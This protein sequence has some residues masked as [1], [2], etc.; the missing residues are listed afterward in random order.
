[1]TLQCCSAT[2]L[3]QTNLYIGKTLVQG[4]INT[5]GTDV[6]S[7]YTAATRIEGFIN[8]FGDS[9]SA[10]TSIL[11]SQNNGGKQK[12]RV[13]ESFHCSLIYLGLLGICSSLILFVSAPQTISFMLGNK[14]DLAFHTG[15]QYLRIISIFYVFCFLGNSFTGYFDGLKKI[16][17]TVFGTTS[18]IILR[19]ILSWLFFSQF[20]LNTVAVASGIGWIWVNLFWAYKKY[21]MK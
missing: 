12:K 18:H 19:V 2:A 14:S 10:S 21:K 17:I 16:S 6:I 20:Q 5:G 13:Q 9:G 7:A 3:Q 11:V 15:V 8:S 1:M 4:I